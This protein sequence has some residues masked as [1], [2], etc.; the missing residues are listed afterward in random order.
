MLKEW[1]GSDQLSEITYINLQNNYG[2]KIRGKK[3]HGSLVS[4]L[5]FLFVYR[6]KFQLKSAFPLFNNCSYTC[7]IH[8]RS[9]YIVHFFSA[10]D[11]N[12]LWTS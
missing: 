3:T 7:Y 4:V 5:H 11:R 1:K 9:Q 6:L 2:F 12:K 8:I 10:P